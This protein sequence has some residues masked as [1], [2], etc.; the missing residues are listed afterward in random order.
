MKAIQI[1]ESGRLTTYRYYDRLIW[2]AH[3]FPPVKT[4]Y[5]CYFSFSFC[6]FGTKVLVSNSRNGHFRNLYIL[7]LCDNHDTRKRKH[8]LCGWNFSAVS[9]L[10]KWPTIC[11][12][13]RSKIHRFMAKIVMITSSCCCC[14]FRQKLWMKNSLASFDLCMCRTRWRMQQEENSHK[15]HMTHKKVENSSMPNEKLTKK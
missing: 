3:N 10:E 8:L 2:C 13:F 1:Q 4:I 6:L 5:I 9:V 7:F 11:S 15:W 12:Y 14:C